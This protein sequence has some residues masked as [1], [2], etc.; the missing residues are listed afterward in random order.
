MTP[1]RPSRSTFQIQNFG[2]R[3][4]LLHLTMT[5]PLIL[6]KTD[7]VCSRMISFGDETYV[8]EYLDSSPESGIFLDDI[9]C[10]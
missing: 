5:S 4:T 7:R 3:K 10:E 2:G 8:R 9:D 1:L 6:K